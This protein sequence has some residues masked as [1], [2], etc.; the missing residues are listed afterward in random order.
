MT[1]KYKH[2]FLMML[3]FRHTAIEKKQQMILFNNDEIVKDEIK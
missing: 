1:I 2:N 3:L